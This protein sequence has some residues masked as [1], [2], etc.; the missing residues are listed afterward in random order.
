MFPFDHFLNLP[1]DSL[2]KTVGLPLPSFM[3]NPQSFTHIVC[4]LGVDLCSTKS[5]QFSLM[6]QDYEFLTWTHT[7]TH[8]LDAFLCN[9]YAFYAKGNVEQMTAL[10]LYFYAFGNHC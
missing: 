1:Q 4:S 7:H 8:T 2:L 10:K 6:G 5:L 3:I 9:F